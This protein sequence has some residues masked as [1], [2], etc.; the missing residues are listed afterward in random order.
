MKVIPAAELATPY[1]HSSLPARL[2]SRRNRE[3]KGKTWHLVFPDGFSIN[4][5]HDSSS[6]ERFKIK[7]MRKIVRGLPFP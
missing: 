1:H 4:T 7:E 2:V 5:L 3:G 6:R